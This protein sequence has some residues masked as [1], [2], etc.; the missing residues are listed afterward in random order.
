MFGGD[1]SGFLVGDNSITPV[2]VAGSVPCGRSVPLGL[3][4]RPNE[5]EHEG[6]A[7]A[8]GRD[9]PICST[10]A[11]GE[12]PEPRLRGVVVDVCGSFSRL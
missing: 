12:A 7:A 4:C 2:L 5:L 9:R 3:D 6:A 8:L 10:R 11:C 1:G